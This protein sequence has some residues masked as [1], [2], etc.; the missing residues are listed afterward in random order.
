MWTNAPGLKHTHTTGWDQN[1]GL[2]TQARS[3][4]NAVAQEEGRGGEGRRKGG[5]GERGRGGEEERRG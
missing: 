3:W 4:G 1:R 5:E 2:V